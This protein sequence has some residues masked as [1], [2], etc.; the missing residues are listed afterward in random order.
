MTHEL[1]LEIKKYKNKSFNNYLQRLN[2]EKTPDYSLWKSTKK[3]KRPTT[4]IHLILMA[5][6]NWTRKNSQKAKLFS[7]YLVGVFSLD[8]DP[9]AITQYPK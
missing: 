3:Y 8:T 5:D 1:R 4:Q 6:G 9:P 2:N 7:N